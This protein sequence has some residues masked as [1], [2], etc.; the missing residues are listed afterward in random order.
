MTASEDDEIVFVGETR[1][2]GGAGEGEAR[3]VKRG[4]YDGTMDTLA[5]Q[6]LDAQDA[7]TNANETEAPHPPATA[8]PNTTRDPPLFRLFRTEHISNSHN[9][10]CV[11]VSDLVRG[12]V[13]WGVVSNFKIDLDFISHAA[14]EL[15]TIPRIHW[16]HGQPD[17]PEW[18][19]ENLPNK[20][21][22]KTWTFLKPQVPN[23]GTH[24]SKF[25]L[26]VYPA[27]VRVVVSTANLCRMDLTVMSNAAWWQDFPLKSEQQLQNHASSEF[28]EDLLLYLNRLRWVGG[29]ETNE[30]GERVLVGPE[31]FRAFDYSGAG[32]KLI[33]S[34]P[35]RH[36]SVEETSWGH[37]ALHRALQKQKFPK[38]FEKSPVLGQFSSMGSFSEKWLNDEFRGSLCGGVIE[39]PDKKPLGKG[40]LNLIWPTKQEVRQSLA[41]YVS[42][43]SIPGSAKNVNKPHVRSKLHTW[44]ANGSQNSEN[45]SDTPTDDNPC[46]RRQAVPHIKTFARYLEDKKNGAKLAWVFLG[47]H[48]LSGAAWG[49][50]EHGNS[51][52]NLLSYELGVLLLPSLVGTRVEKP[53]CVVAASAQLAVEEVGPAM[54]CLAGARPCVAH[55]RSGKEVVFR[56]ATTVVPKDVSLS[57]GTSVSTVFAPLPYHVPPRRYGPHDV[58]WTFDE[59]HLKPDWTGQQWHPRG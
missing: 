27:G 4:R 35:V 7:K 59:T 52:L 2:A 44:S 57:E 21:E 49:K 37:P 56:H 50:F 5:Y 23:Y 38:E 45:N 17:V 34:V 42:G 8:T 1:A 22:D 15:L 53:F 26:L 10:G 32:A 25:F 9:D 19:K 16:L 14:P 24:H 54:Q 30:D 12:P 29:E 31:A 11:T 51:Q 36:N 33:R 20:I 18:T 46:G 55:G 41:G 28:E 39:G 48:N 3:G 47:S 43:G 40:Q 13:K 6:A 58:P